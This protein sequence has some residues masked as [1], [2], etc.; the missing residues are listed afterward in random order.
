MRNTLTMIRL[1]RSRF[2]APLAVALVCF[3]MASTAAADPALRTQMDLRGNF[4]LLGA[5]LAH[6]CTPDVPAPV[7]G[8]VDNCPNNNLFAPDVYWRADAPADGQARAD[9]SFT[10]ADARATAVLQLP[11]GAQVV[12]ARLYWGGLTDSMDGDDE[13]R[14]ERPD[15]GLD[16]SITADDVIALAKP[17]E[18]GA[19]F[20][21]STADITDLVVAEGAGP[22]R[23]G[24]VQSSLT[25]STQ[26]GALSAWY[27]VVFYELDGEPSRNLAIF[28]GLDIVDVFNPRSA[29]LSGF[30]VP[31]AAFDA[32]LGVVG[33]EGEDQLVGD[34]LRFNGTDL[35]NALNPADNFFNAT[36]SQ[37]GVAVSNAGDL[38]QLTGGARSYSNVDLDVVDVTSL[39][40][41]GDTSATIEAGVTNIL[42]LDQFILSAFVTS[43]STL[44]PDLTPTTKEVV[45]LNGGVP[46]PGDVLEYR[47]VVRN[48]GSDATA[49]LE[50]VDELPDGVSFVSG[51]LSIESG[52]N[53]GAKTDAAGDDQAE[54]DDATRTV[55][56]RLGIG[57]DDTDGGELAIG[58]ETELRFQV[59]ID[60]DVL[61]EIANQGVVTA[62]GAQGSMPGETLTDGDPTQA[63]QS[64]TPVFVEECEDD[65]QC[66]APTPFCDI[67]REPRQCVGC[68]NSGQ[69]TDP[70]APDCD[71]DTGTCECADPSGVCDDMDMDGISDG[72]EQDLGT[73]PMDADTDDDGVLDGDEVGPDS[74]SDGDGVI[75]ALDPDSDNDG[76]PDGTELGLGCDH[77]DTD[78]SAGKCRPDG[79]MGATITSPVERDTDSG[80][81]SDGSEDFDLDGVIDDGET[82][83]TLGNGADDVNVIDSDDDGLGDEL[84]D[85][86]NSDPN[87]ADSDDDG[88]SDGSE[89]DPAVD[90][91]GDGLNTVL[92]PD[93]DDDGL[94]DGT[95][96]GLDCSF[97]ATDAS[98]GH[99]RPDGDMGA[100]TTSPVDADTD[101]G[102]VRDGSED[103]NLN[104]VV[105]A[106]ET[107]PTA[108][109]GADDTDNADAD[110]DG[111]SDG[112]EGQIGTD[113]NDADSDDDGLPDGQEPNPSD[114]HDGDGL[115]NP[116]DPDSDDD[117]LFDGTERGKGCADAATDAARM[118]CVADADGGATVTSAVNDD[119]DFG[120]EPDGSEDPNL[121]GAIDTGERDPN[122]PADDNVCSTDQDC[123]EMFSGLICVDGT[124]VEGCRGEGGNVCPDGEY[125][126][127]M[128]GAA[129]QCLPLRL[130]NF[131]GGGCDCSLRQDSPRGALPTLLLVALSILVSVRRRRR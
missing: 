109:N 104:G 105:D 10:A 86:L 96:L 92:D 63:G 65:S 39:V 107:D 122:D 17:G 55:S 58:E 94:F 81:V 71:T 121:D 98:R 2:A 33:F 90:T 20:Y 46:A 5:T 111:L 108:G 115:V 3:G 11:A 129:G 49:D 106:G 118:Q 59:E 6:E 123:G 101:D 64:P 89:P 32:S 1:T 76:L 82:N 103:V 72:A 29:S 117:G 69:C 31:P 28:D 36:R 27:M 85:N 77:P 47:I 110:G 120:G 130:P 68:A 79:D 8:T 48:Q 78:L 91:D 61:G 112:L 119:T 57:A 54:Y 16:E 131:G 4:V 34:F 25:G 23:V 9:A 51:S 93:S 45:D 7:V 21:Q 114:D 125:C 43:I 24:G 44:L 37:M 13:A 128:D 99:C 67:A 70:A 87:D 38:P 113:P 26:F 12:H 84:E 52:P 30:V 22:Y 42:G 80:G 14:I 83:P 126:S 75:N 74:D 95:E 127:S 88:V 50:L 56:A 73:D 41:G 53:A 116:L 19:F 60:G 18:I 35:E 40:S 66:E 100:T 97:A 102:G 124:C 15:T 62:A